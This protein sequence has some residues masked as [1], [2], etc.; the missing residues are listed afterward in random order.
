MNGLLFRRM[1]SEKRIKRLFEER[2]EAI[3]KKHNSS[4]SEKPLARLNNAETLF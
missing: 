3:E 2:D 1:K 4:G